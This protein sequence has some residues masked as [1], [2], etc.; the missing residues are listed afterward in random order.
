ML[1]LLRK[2]RYWML[3]IGI[4]GLVIHLG[5]QL[6]RT[7]VWTRPDN[8]FSSDGLMFLLISAT[9]LGVTAALIDELIRTREYLQHRAV[10]HARLFWT[11]Q[12]GCLLVVAAWIV[13]VPALHL[14]LTVVVRQDSALIDG[15][16]YWTLVDEG[17]PAFVFY[18]VSYFCATLVRRLIWALPLAALAVA[19]VFG[20][21]VHRSEGDDAWSRLPLT[22]I[23]LLV[24][25]GLLLAALVNERQGREAD[26][27]WTWPRLRSAGMVLLLIVV[28]GAAF[29]LRGVQNSLVD[30]LGDA[31]PQVAR[32]AGGA[33]TLV[34]YRI[35]HR[36]PVLVDDQHRIQ[37]DLPRDSLATLWTSEYA[38]LRRP[39]PGP[40]TFAGVARRGRT[41]GGIRYTAI[42][43]PYFL[44]CYVRS[45]GFVTVVRE[46]D[47][48]YK[49]LWGNPPGLTDLPEGAHCL[50]R[51]GSDQPFAAGAMPIG[52]W[53]NGTAYVADPGTGQ[54]W[55]ADLNQARPA[56]ARVDLPGADRFVADVTDDSRFR[57]GGFGV[58][59]AVVV[60]GRRGV[61]V[62]GD[63]GGWVPAPAALAKLAS[64]ETAARALSF[65]V[66]PI[67]P[68]SFALDVTD[69]DQRVVLHHLYTPRTLLER[70]I[71]AS[72]TAGTLLRPP[73][74]SAVSRVVPFTVHR[75]PGPMWVLDPLIP[76]ASGWLL[77]ANL[78]IGAAL[79]AL[80]QRR[81]ARL[82]AP[83]D[84][85]L[86]W[87]I[88][89]V[90]GGVPAYVCAR[91]IETR[92]AWQA[93]PAAEVA[94]AAPRLLIESA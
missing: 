59:V 18:A 61:Y 80:A 17:T 2:D 79:A 50:G 47:N 9:P 57:P 65:A 73:L 40:L 34:A 90:L 51:D 91:L 92:R 68:F 3:G 15:A 36:R 13:L 44:Y 11:R 76:I 77:L 66:D 60:A 69:A 26:L 93:L 70:A 54:I 62:P 64:A 6:E 22:P 14:A 71:A 31:Y 19:C 46:V 53:W 45:D 78:L 75:T 1:A 33:P 43:C 49:R 30:S 27:P 63:E 20:F 12:L 7:G 88:A 94:P 48:L 55:A 28:P 39:V 32:I 41:F 81:L 84:R 37:A 8:G 87:T 29:G 24:S 89:V 23:C 5:A 74:F 10:S 52:N 72:I 21:V 58:A 85:R 56:F 42:P 82:G 86:T 35:G 16:R 38:V 83:L 67:G 4:A 25:A